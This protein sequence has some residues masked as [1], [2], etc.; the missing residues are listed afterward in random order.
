MWWVIE[1][2]DSTLVRIGGA[3]ITPLSIFFFVATLVVAIVVA[4]LAR[5]GIARFFRRRRGTRVGLGYSLGRIVQYV[6][7]LIGFLVG[8]NGLGI[9]LTAVAA[10]GAIL[11]VGIGFGLQNIAQN[12]ISGL[13]LLIERPVQKGDFVV[14]GDT[15]GTVHDISMRATRI[16]T[17]DGVA[18][19]V[20]NSALITGRVENQSAPTSKYRVRIR[21]GVAY[22]SE[23][24]RVRSTLCEV[25]AAHPAVLEDP[26]P[27][28]FFLSF[29][30][31]AMVFELAVW[32]DDPQPEP[33]VTSDLRFA[34]EAAF[35]Q[36]KI[37]I[38]FPQL[39]VRL[40]S[41]LEVLQGEQPPAEPRRGNGERASEAP[42]PQVVDT[43]REE[44]RT[45]ERV[46]REFEEVEREQ[47]RPE[48]RAA[49][50]E[51]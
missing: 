16:V 41:G 5:K 18:I 51:E 29:G 23:V 28:V 9:D 24:E 1:N 49:D 33:A 34:I 30:D 4:R 25:G 14:I 22:G 37:E 13:I 15:V 31:N 46:R 38:A 7:V 47:H 48:G 10:V 43:S 36:R 17:R 11:T 8:L 20:P 12:F 40:R 2:L 19:I 42:L 26:P 27:K 35:R 39:D 3:D 32:L 44:K 21:V 45:I 50:A 6:I